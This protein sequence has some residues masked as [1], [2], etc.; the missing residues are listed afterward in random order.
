MQEV[1][2]KISAV[3]QNTLNG[4]FAEKEEKIFSKITK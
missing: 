4:F 2:M 1:F 3:F